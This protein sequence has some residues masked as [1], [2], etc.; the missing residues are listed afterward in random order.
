M[1]LRFYHILPALLLVA[2]TVWGQSRARVRKSTD[3]LA[4]LPVATGFATT[5]ALKDYTGLK[6]LAL[7]GGTALATSYLLELCI[8][9]DRPD[10]DG[11]HAFP[12]THTV[13]AFQGAS[14]IQRR[15]GWKFGI[16]AYAVASY[17]GWGRIYAQRHDIWDVLAGAA[18]GVGATY[19]F[20][21]PFAKEVNLSVAPATFGNTH[22]GFYAS[23]TF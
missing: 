12:S 2:P 1:R 7:S 14:F 11:H 20:T 8:R 13:V 15:Y 22:V 9:K 21:R 6:Q 10:G 16:P 5:L 4:L 17:V 3:V 23:M 18:I 19:V